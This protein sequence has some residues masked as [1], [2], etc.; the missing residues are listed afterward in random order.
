MTPQKLSLA[1]SGASNGAQLHGPWH[2]IGR[3]EGDGV[4]AV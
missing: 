3:L 1:Y 4:V 2:P